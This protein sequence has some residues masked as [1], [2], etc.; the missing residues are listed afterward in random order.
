MQTDW[1]DAEKELPTDERLHP[2][3]IAP[4]SGHRRKAGAARY[5]KS[6]RAWVD[7]AGRL[8]AVIAWAKNE[9]E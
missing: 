3:Q 4:T 1:I 5:S 9:E 7:D 2:V 8:A 6:L